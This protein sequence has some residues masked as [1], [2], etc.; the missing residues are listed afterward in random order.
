MS[1][2][3]NSSVQ[4]DFLNESRYSQL[5]KLLGDIFMEILS[6]EQCMTGLELEFG[7][8]YFLGK[9]TAAVAAKPIKRRLDSTQKQLNQIHLL[10]FI[11]I[12]CIF[13]KMFSTL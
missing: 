10:S 6:Q 1:S 2:E 7:R 8:R 4:H 13:S 11:K 5:K 12:L 3:G 9:S